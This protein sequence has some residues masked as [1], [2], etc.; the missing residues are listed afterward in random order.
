MKEQTGFNLFIKKLVNYFLQGLLYVSPLGITIYVIIYVFNQVD[1]ILL[2][3]IRDYTHI[4][5]PGLGAILMVLL[6]TILGY[7]GQSVLG[8]PFKLVVERILQR[9]PILNMVYTS[10]RDFMEA[11]VG[12]EKKFNQPVLIKI[13][14][15]SEVE[16]MGFITQNDL[17]ELS[18]KEKVAVYIPFAYAFSGE[19]YIVPS[20]YVTF[21][22]VSAGEWMK[23]IISG[24]ITKV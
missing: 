18:I 5:I 16:R 6:I 9:A 10:I 11:F 24:G 3:L 4:K 15:T 13:G 7:F 8:R 20:S 17:T 22:N 12:K 23:F 14:A 1:G 2:P 21:V 19:L